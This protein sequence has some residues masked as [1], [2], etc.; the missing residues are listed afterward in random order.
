MTRELVSKRTRNEFREFLVGWTLREIEIEFKGANIEC[1]RNFESE[2]SGQR[3]SFVEQYYRTLDFTKPADV[4]RLL[5]AYQSIIERAAGNLPTNHGRAEAERALEHLKACLERDGFICDG[6]NIAATTPEARVVFEQP[7]AISE[8][9]RRAVFDELAVGQIS[10]CGRLSEHN[11]LARL[12]DLEKLPSHDARF[13]SMTGDIGQHR[14]NNLDWDDD[15]VFSDSRLDLMGATDD[16]FLR[17]LCEMVHPAVRPDSK[18]AKALVTTFNEHVLVDGWELVEGKRISGRPTFVARRRASGTVALPDPVYATDVLSDEYVREL[19]GKCDSRLASDDLDGA[20]TVARTLLE[21][22]LSE[23]EVRLAG[24]KGN[25]KGDLP[26]QFKQVT[27]LL[28]MDEQRSDLDDRFKDVIRGLVMVANGLAPLRN[29][30]S[31]G[32]A[33][34]RKP[35]PHHARVVVNAAKTVSAFL[36]ESYAYQI[37]KGLIENVSVGAKEASS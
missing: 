23:L 33:R 17:F 9:T 21:A 13:D 34:E 7:R 25:Y 6:G 28:H 5:A 15:W 35:A 32:H 3:R 36:V 22:V 18:E 4:K 11:F 30:M 37:A 14:E 20:V 2:V 8:I 27:K 26:R 19:A 29:K 12:Y 1:D 31:D 16:A 24:A 10:W